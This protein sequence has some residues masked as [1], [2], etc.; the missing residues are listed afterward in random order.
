MSEIRNIGESPGFSKAS[1]A[2]MDGSEKPYLGDP[3]AVEQL[4]RNED[5]PCMM[6]LGEP[7]YQAELMAAGKRIA[8][9]LLGKDPQWSVVEGWNDPG[10]VDEFVAKWAGVEEKDPEDRIIGAF[11]G[12]IRD[13]EA[14]EN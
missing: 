11:L 4:L 5:G 7:G 12:L 1:L 14:I 3:Q 10:V 6:I 8:H 13:L 9:A 2:K